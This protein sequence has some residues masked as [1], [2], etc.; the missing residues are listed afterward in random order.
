MKIN[1]D[2]TKEIVFKRPNP[3]LTVH[4]AIPAHVADIEQVRAAKLLGVVLC[5]SLQFYEHVHAVLK[6]CSQRM[7]LMKL[8]RDQGLPSKELHCIFYALV[9]SKIRYAMPAWSGFLSAHL[10]G[11][12]NGLLK[13]AHR[14]G[15]TLDVIS[16]K[17]IAESVDSKLFKSITHSNHCLH[18]LLPRQGS[19]ILSPS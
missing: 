15:F 13:R 2:K 16:V 19:G 6:T 5:D 9:V 12:I 17:D 18:F 1:L 11:Q 3:R 7:Y 10:V 4:P 8:L 14:Y